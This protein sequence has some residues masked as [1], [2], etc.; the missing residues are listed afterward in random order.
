[1]NVFI[2]DLKNEPGS[3]ASLAEAIAA[4]GINIEA[5]TGA[6]CGG[7]GS[8]AI[9]T[10]DEDGT[11]K[12][13]SEKGFRAREVE[14]VSASIEHKPGTLAAAAR[15]L[16]DGG[17]NIEAA[18]PMGMSEGKVTLAFATDQPAK[19]RT[20]LGSATPAGIGVR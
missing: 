11:R 20:I 9:A 15:K 14:L 12:A 7:S 17:V 10:N 13:L 18:F 1:M 19:A 6:T 16:A 3:L 5:F 2:V 8:V 4:K